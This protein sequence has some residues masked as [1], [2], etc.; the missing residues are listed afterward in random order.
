MEIRAKALFFLTYV[1]K[2]IPLQ[3][4]CKHFVT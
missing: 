2:E 3:G 1:K 4:F